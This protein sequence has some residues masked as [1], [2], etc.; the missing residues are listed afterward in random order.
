M[1]KTQ[2]EKVYKNRGKRQREGLSNKKVNLSY[3]YRRMEF[4]F[5]KKK[6]G[7]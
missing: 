5:I 6:L 2:K 4:I 1:E 7:P 3:I